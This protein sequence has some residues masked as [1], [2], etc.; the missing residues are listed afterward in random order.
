MGV[1]E[2]LGILRVAPAHTHLTLKDTPLADTTRYDWLTSSRGMR[3]SPPI[4]A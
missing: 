1:A 3:A 2:S 4:R